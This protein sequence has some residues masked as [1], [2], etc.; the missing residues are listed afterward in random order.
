MCERYF[1]LWAGR[2]GQFSRTSTSKQSSREFCWYQPIRK[3]YITNL[4]QF[5]LYF[6]GPKAL[7]V[8]DNEK[9]VYQKL[10]HEVCI[11][12]FISILYDQES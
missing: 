7:V 12:I 11:E 8:L 3:F 2:I 9:K 10:R 5:L 1:L 4:S 6:S